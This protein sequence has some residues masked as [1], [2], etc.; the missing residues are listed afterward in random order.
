MCFDCLFNNTFDRFFEKRKIKQNPFF[1]LFEME[2]N[3]L[4][5]PLKISSIRSILS[6]Y[7]LNL[8]SHYKTEFTFT[9]VAVFKWLMFEYSYTVKTN[10]SAHHSIVPFILSYLL[11]LLVNIYCRYNRNINSLT[12]KTFSEWLNYALCYMYTATCIL[13][14]YLVFKIFDWK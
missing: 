5:I 3:L 6:Y 1:I 4:L 9:F 13:N 8:T 2:N 10:L 14:K 7:T 11:N 12:R